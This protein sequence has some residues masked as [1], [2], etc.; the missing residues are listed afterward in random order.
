MYMYSTLTFMIM[1]L[2]RVFQHFASSFAGS[3]C[4]VHE[5]R[6]PEHGGLPHAPV[7]I[8]REDTV[9]S[10]MQRCALKAHN[11]DTRHS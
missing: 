9:L 10:E 11:S 7:F 1:N 5:G 6:V 2:P 3:V 8:L 4:A